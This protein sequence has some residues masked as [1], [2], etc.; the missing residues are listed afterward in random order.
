[1]VSLPGALVERC[2][3]AVYWTPGLTL[4][5]LAEEALTLLLDAMEK[6]RGEP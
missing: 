3:D 6:N 5:G 1:M 4:A 2:R